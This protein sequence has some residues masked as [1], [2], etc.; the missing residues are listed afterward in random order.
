VDVLPRLD[1]RCKGFP[2]LQSNRWGLRERRDFARTITKQKILTAKDAMF[3]KKIEESSF[4][5]GMGHP[6]FSPDVDFY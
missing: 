5:N 4:M 2:F 1:A 6:M 3:A